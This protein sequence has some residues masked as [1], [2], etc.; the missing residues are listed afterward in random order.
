[1]QR[2]TFGVTLVV[3]TIAA[4]IFIL[5]PWLVALKDNPYV[6]LFVS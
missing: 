4:I 5:F 3:I 1:M 2:W 6:K